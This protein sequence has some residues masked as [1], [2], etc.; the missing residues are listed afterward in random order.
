MTLKQLEK[1]KAFVDTTGLGAGFRIYFGVDNL[2]ESEVTN[3]AF[4]FDFCI[5]VSLHDGVKIQE[6]FKMI[7]DFKSLNFGHIRNNYHDMAK[8]YFILPTWLKK[9]PEKKGLLFYVLFGDE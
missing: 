6:G 2:E 5:H 9:F 7:G 1:H 3:L 4:T 8:S